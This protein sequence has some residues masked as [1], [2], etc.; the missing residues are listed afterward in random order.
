MRAYKTK[1]LDNI[2]NKKEFEKLKELWFTKDFWYY[3][4]SLNNI[5]V[6]LDEKWWFLDYQYRYSWNRIAPNTINL[7][8]ATDLWILIKELKK[9]NII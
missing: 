8:E 2:Y 6:W 3:I 9:F 5:V 7:K 1:K 4:K